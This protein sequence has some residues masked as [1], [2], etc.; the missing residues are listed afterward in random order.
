MKKKFNHFIPEATE[1]TWHKKKPNDGG[2]ISRN[3]AEKHYDKLRKQ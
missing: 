3:V 1:Q 2:S